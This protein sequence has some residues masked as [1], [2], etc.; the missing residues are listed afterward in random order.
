MVHEAVAPEECAEDEVSG[1]Q[2]MG[3]GRLILKFWRLSCV[4]DQQVATIRD[5]ATTAAA[6]ATSRTITDMV[7]TT[8]TVAAATTTITVVTVTT[9]DTTIR[10]ITMVNT[11]KATTVLPIITITTTR[12][13]LNLQRLIAAW[14]P[15]AFSYKKK[16]EWLRTLK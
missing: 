12:S 16:S 11:I 14:P 10:A 13:K 7:A 15:P 4:P 8:A 3:I 1:R 9:V 5:G 2:C 6:G